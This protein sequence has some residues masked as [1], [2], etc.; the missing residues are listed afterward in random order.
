MVRDIIVVLSDR[1][2]GRDVALVAIP[3]VF[4]LDIPDRPVLF[5]VYVTAEQGRRATCACSGTSSAQEEPPR[6]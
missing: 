3:K 6:F 4:S 5:S 2:I 1:G